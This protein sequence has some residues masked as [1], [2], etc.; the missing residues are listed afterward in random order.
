VLALFHG[1][2][3]APGKID[4]ELFSTVRTQVTVGVSKS[5]D[6]VCSIYRTS[7]DGKEVNGRAREIKLLAGNVI[8]HLITLS[9]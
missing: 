2:Q 6:S 8:F 3:G 5:S 4:I 1:S 7:V 9:S